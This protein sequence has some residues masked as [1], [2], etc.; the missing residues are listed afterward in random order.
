MEK[1]LK[2]MNLIYLSELLASFNSTYKMVISGK[3][4]K[5][6]KDKISQIAL[7]ITSVQRLFERTMNLELVKEK[8][9][10]DTGVEEP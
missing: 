4:Q 6:I 2:D 3:N 5:D 1:K 7:K 10:L 9:K 8:L